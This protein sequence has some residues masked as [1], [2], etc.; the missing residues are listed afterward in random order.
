M[1]K[2]LAVSVVLLNTLVGAYAQE[3]GNPV[4]YHSQIVEGLR[5]Q[6]R[7]NLRNRSVHSPEYAGWERAQNTLQS[8]EVALGEVAEARRVC[9]DLMSGDQEMIQK[10][11]NVIGHIQ[12]KQNDIQGNFDNR[13][14]F[15]G[16]VVHRLG[17]DLERTLASRPMRDSSARA[18]GRNTTRISRIRM[19]LMNMEIIS[20]IQYDRRNGV[21]TREQRYDISF[22]ENALGLEVQEQS[23]E[24]RLRTI[25]SFI[26]KVVDQSGITL[27]QA[28]GTH[29]DLMR[30]SQNHSD[31]ALPTQEDLAKAEAYKNCQNRVAEIDNTFRNYDADDFVDYQDYLEKVQTFT[32]SYG[33]VSA[34]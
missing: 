6:N 4:D 13:A 3:A 30:T 26:V 21:D 2:T 33:E 9:E 32:R 28:Y 27:P 7:D 16:T 15:D 29:V 20:P 1:K 23:D 14:P 18:L 12:R 11:L 31:P 5:N 34:Q 10:Q 8:L 25:E 22:L 19:V 17:R 24:E